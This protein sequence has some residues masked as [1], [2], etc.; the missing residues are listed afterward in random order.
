MQR[1]SRESTLKMTL[2]RP[3]GATRNTELMQP[4]QAQPR[5]AAPAGTQF[6]NMFA[7]RIVGN[8]GESSGV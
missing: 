7:K 3:K 8:K 1:R 5:S 6:A 4:S 2:P